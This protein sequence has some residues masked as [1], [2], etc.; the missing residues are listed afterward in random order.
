VPGQN[1]FDIRECQNG[2]IPEVQAILAKSPEAAHWSDQ[3]IA[4]ALAASPSYHLVSIVGGEIAGFIFGRRIA[5]EGEILNL[6]V[7]PAFRR[8]GVG[9]ALVNTILERFNRDRVR[10][11]FLEVRESNQAAICFYQGLGFRQIGRREAY[12]SDPPAAALVLALPIPP[13]PLPL[14]N[15]KEQVL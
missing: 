8:Q 13:P 9:Q 5:V 6:A 15:P 3:A 11:V 12:Y 14:A 4:D 10:Q 1:T 7:K 2:N